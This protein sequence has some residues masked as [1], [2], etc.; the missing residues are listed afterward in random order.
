MQDR[1]YLTNAYTRDNDPK[2]YVPRVE[3]TNVTEIK[4]RLNN[5]YGLNLNTYSNA[6]GISNNNSYQG[7]PVD[8]KVSNNTF[9]YNPT[10]VD[11]QE[12]NLKPSNHFKRNNLAANTVSSKPITNT[13]DK[14]S[15]YNGTKYDYN[16]AKNVRKPYEKEDLS[17]NEHATVNSTKYLGTSKKPENL[18]SAKNMPIKRKY[19]DLKTENKEKLGN[20]NT[21]ATRY[22]YNTSKKKTSGDD[23]TSTLT[24]TRSTRK[25]TPAD[26]LVDNDTPK[27]DTGKNK[28]FFHTF[29]SG[30]PTT[31]RTE[32]GAVT[33]IKYDEYSS[34]VDSPSKKY[35]VD[36]NKQ[37]NDVIN[38]LLP[39]KSTATHYQKDTTAN[40]QS[41]ASYKNTKAIDESNKS[42]N[43]AKKSPAGYMNS[44]NPDE[45]QMNYSIGYSTVNSDGV[46]IV[47][48]DK[49][50][51]DD[52]KNDIQ[53]KDSD[54]KIKS[55]LL[56][57]SELNADKL[58]KDKLVVKEELEKLKTENNRKNHELVDLKIEIS[59]MKKEELNH[60]S[61]GIK[62]E[63][64]LESYETKFQSFQG[65][66]E[67]AMSNLDNLKESQ[68]KKTSGKKKEFRQQIPVPSQFEANIVGFDPTH[69]VEQSKTRAIDDQY[70]DLFGNNVKRANSINQ[71]PYEDFKEKSEYKEKSDQESLKDVFLD[72]RDRL[73]TIFESIQQGPI[74]LKNMDC[75]LSNK[76]DSIIMNDKKPEYEQKCGLHKS[77]SFVYESRPSKYVKRNTQDRDTSFPSIDF[78]SNINT[79]KLYSSNVLEES[80][81][82]YGTTKDGPQESFVE[83]NNIRFD[84]IESVGIKPSLKIG[85]RLEKSE[86]FS[87]TVS[88]VK[89]VYNVKQTPLFQDDKSLY[90]QHVQ[91][92]MGDLVQDPVNGKMIVK[93]S[94]TLKEH[95]E[96]S[97]K[98]SA[99][100]NHNL[101][102]IPTIPKIPQCN[103]NKMVSEEA[104]QPRDQPRGRDNMMNRDD[105]RRKN[106]TSRN[107]F[108]SLSKTHQIDVIPDD[109]IMLK[110]WMFKQSKWIKKWR[111]RWCVLTTEAQYSFESQNI[112]T[113]Y[114]EKIILCTILSIDQNV[115]DCKEKNAFRINVTH[116]NPQERSFLF[117]VDNEKNKE[118]WIAMV[119]KIADKTKK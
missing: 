10:L 75:Y 32:P 108:R 36:S 71:K 19:G 107:F 5:K 70:S 8:N 38:N 35:K 78:V 55:D 81:Y 110:D 26:V 29:D 53:K 30:L 34:K 33:Y 51:Y 73:G 87:E 66:L 58:K 72:M 102:T 111:K 2:N 99:D 98:N 106:N 93:N 31:P 27:L 54:I 115:A 44:Q 47:V 116:D 88:P 23:I 67:G 50:E 59:A 13:T 89:K 74:D 16:S 45:K 69:T 56:K 20:Y 100:K 11:K 82:N 52:L 25:Q 86:C 24:P 104:P 46:S 57:G 97:M 103:M 77:Q 91:S 109:E 43:N 4:S 17:T 68:K 60:K 42:M 1:K 18:G 95:A 21:Y 39:N 76:E 9:D 119:K 80:S 96:A 83:F 6:D 37:L 117:Y 85:A 41:N 90:G 84:K 65:L 49:K 118:K 48:V 3:K 40:N 7:T 12:E 94:A 114:T 64:I 113:K 14:L 62:H 112:K 15:P 22:N 79:E 101:K 28:T 105:S 92:I 61:L 63:K